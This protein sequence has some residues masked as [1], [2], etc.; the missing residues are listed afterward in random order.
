MDSDPLAPWLLAV[1]LGLY[2]SALLA[3][4]LG[5]HASA[6]IVDRGDRSRVLQSAALLACAALIFAAL[7]LAIANVQLG[8]S[9]GSII[10]PATLAWTWPTLAPSSIAFALSGA[11]AL[12]AWRFRGP[13]AA[14]AAIALAAGFALTGHTQ[15]L[16]NPGLAPWG[17]GLHALIAAFWIAAPITLWPRANLSDEV[18]LSRT[19]RFSRLALVLVPVLFLIGIWLAILLAGSVNALFS[20]LYGQL[21]LAKLGVASAALA[22]GA[23]NKHIV[24]RKL[25]QAPAEGRRAL[26]VTLAFDTLLFASALIVV[27]VATTFTGPPTE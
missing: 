8:G 5:L 14:L 23:Y 4:G 21:L 15:A 10:D 19:A 6:N 17:V 11:L 24:A 7:R 12:A 3:A 18:V 13:L 22:L 2:A 26:T 20:S 9:I 1:K 25:R 16:E 27:G